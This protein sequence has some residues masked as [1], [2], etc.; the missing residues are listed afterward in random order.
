MEEFFR[1]YYK[2]I[3]NYAACFNLNF[4]DVEEVAVDVIMEC[5]EDYKARTPDEATL[6]RWICRRVMLS[7][8]SLYRTRARY[9]KE[10]ELTQAIE[11]RLTHLD[12]P[13]A[14][15]SLMQRIPPAIHPILINY[16]QFGGNVTERGE[17]TN[18]DRTRFCRERKKFLVSLDID[19]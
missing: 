17:N 6:S 7:T 5:Y 9:Y 16:V 12:D 4:H 11:D 13:E 3:C 1:R 19:K 18:A 8:K 10:Q 2:R 15:C 14:I